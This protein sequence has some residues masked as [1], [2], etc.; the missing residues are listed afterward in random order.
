M[1]LNLYSFR[2]HKCR[3]SR[4]F[5]NKSAVISTA[6]MALCSTLKG[7]PIYGLEI[8]LPYDVRCD[9]PEVDYAP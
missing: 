5:L 6:V 4:D 9:S 8:V 3:G 1:W 7:F 2:F